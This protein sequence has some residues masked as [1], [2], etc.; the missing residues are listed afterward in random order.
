MNDQTDDPGFEPKQ[1]KAAKRLKKR[2]IV[3]L[4]LL[5]IFG[6]Y[7]F[8]RA[9][10]FSR[11]VQVCH[12]ALA[13]QPQVFD[14]SLKVAT[15]NIA[16]GRGATDDNWA[17][18]KNAKEDRIKEIARQI[19][20][21][22]A[23]VVVL[24]EVDFSATWSGGVDQ[25]A[26]ISEM[27]G[28]EYF[29]TQSNL[30]F[31]MLYGRW[32]FGNVVMSK[33][34]IIE[35]DVVALAPVNTWEDWVV[36]AKRGVQCTIELAPDNFISFVGVHME[37]RGESV[38]VRQ[39]VDLTTECSKLEHPIFVAGDLNTTPSF[40]PFSSVDQNDENAFEKLVQPT[41]TGLSY[42][43]ALAPTEAELTFPSGKPKT[44]IDW[45]LYEDRFYQLVS[46]DV[47]H[48]LLSDHLTVI[49][50]FREAKKP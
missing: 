50:E 5:L 7:I 45:I 2:W 42:S 47:I 20:E 46:Q 49:A 15:W 30:D 10:S 12:N 39:A 16:H 26:A 23:D 1:S 3:W 21:L 40:A 13:V 24:N 35:A 14:G 31:G 25:A 29:V 37:A 32:H 48:S 19:E 34:P 43:P 6:P 38:R 4:A 9:T 11:K 22:G 28:Y 41:A 27:A 17:E 8:F 44:V 36:G 18:G 33:Y